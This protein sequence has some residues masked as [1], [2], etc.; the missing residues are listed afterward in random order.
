MD[1]KLK[2]KYLY[3]NKYKIKCAIGKRGITI[4]KVEGDGKTPAGIFKFKSIFY[5]KDKIPKIK[6]KLQKFV[7]RKNMGW[8]DD[9]NSKQY[10][11]LVK[12][13]FNFKAEKL[14]LT[15]NIYDIIIIINYN[16]NPIKKKKGSAIFLHIAKKNYAPT[17]GCVAISKKN[18]ILLVNKI[19]TKTRLKIY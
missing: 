2:N 18:M 7:I 10:N 8:C 13:P 1:I 19:D 17:K 11:R 16:T 5:R 4:R 9:V 15:K 6:G 12:F 14:W 3:F